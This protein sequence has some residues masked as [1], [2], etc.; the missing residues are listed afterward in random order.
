MCEFKKNCSEEQGPVGERGEC[1]GGGGAEA[2]TERSFS[3]RKRSIHGHWGP[4]IRIKP[5]DK[6][7]TFTFGEGQTRDSDHTRLSNV[8]GAQGDLRKRGGILQS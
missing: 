6:Q 2:H 4:H 8:L 3:Q 5:E 7:R 1:H